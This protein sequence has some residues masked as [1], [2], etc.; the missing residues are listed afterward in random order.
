MPHFELNAITI[1]AVLAAM[2]LP[3]LNKARAKAKS[4]KCVANLKQVGI[5]HLNYCSDNND[6][7]A[8]YFSDVVYGPTVT[9]TWVHRIILNGYLPGR[10]FACPAFSPQAE[11]IAIRYEQLLNLNV[12]SNGNS[13]AFGITNYGY[14]R[15][16]I[17]ADLIR[18]GGGEVPAKTTQL[19]K[20]S[21]IFVNIDTRKVGTDEGVNN[22]QPVASSTASHGVAWLYHE[23]QANVCWADGHVS[24]MTGSGGYSLAGAQSL[25]QPGK[26][27]RYTADD[28]RHT[29]SNKAN[30]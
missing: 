10:V 16:F 12:K 18:P 1:I 5:G 17:G 9:E 27:N 4:G 29:R 7:F 19:S 22:T 26:L 8:P 21:S 25:Y 6:F 24:A 14:N 2:L 15:Y 20:P 23:N 13:Y 3:A 28:N 11:G 30:Y